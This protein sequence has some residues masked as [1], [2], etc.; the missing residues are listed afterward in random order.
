MFLTVD[1]RD[2][3][4]FSHKIKQ[5]LFHDQATILDLRHKLKE[6]FFIN[7]SDQILFH[8]GQ[9]IDLL[10]GTLEEIG[11]KHGDTILLKHDKL[12]MWLVCCDF[13][14]K[15]A[16]KNAEPVKARL[17]KH[18]S[19]ILVILE[20]SNF[21]VT[22]TSFHDKLEELSGMFDCYVI[23]IEESIQK[24]VRVYFKK[25][26]ADEAL[27]IK[28]SPKPSTGAQGGFIAHVADDIFFV[29][30]HAF[31]DRPS[32]H[33]RVDKREIFIY[34]LLH[35]IP[36]AYPG[37]FTSA[38]ALHIATKKVEGFQ[39]RAQRSSCPFTAAHQMQLDLI[40]NIFYLSD[41]NSGNYGI[42]E[43]LQLTIIDFVVLP[44]EC[45]IHTASMFGQQ[46]DHPS[47]NVI[48]KNWDLLKNFTEATESITNDCKQ[49]SNIIWRE[50]YDEFLKVVLE[51]I[52]L[53]NKML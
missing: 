28:F 46:L 38:I 48:V 44:Q 40:K 31:V 45:C 13:A 10:F 26:F 51:N 18:A 47:L 3:E 11:V 5:I 6:K 43:K 32:A 36:S 1:L 39:T 7:K 52:K 53:L 15:L 19:K 37:S 4:G 50:G 2:S 34:R 12:D 35:F 21:F 8:N 23:G 42:D 20:D 33:S 25:F 49:M 30:N 14:G 9:R 24:A 29:K 41:L 27:A 17:A 16:K 22:Y